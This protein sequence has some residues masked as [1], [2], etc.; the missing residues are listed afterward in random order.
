MNGYDHD[1]TIIV[2]DSIFTMVNTRSFEPGIDHYVISRQC[3]QVFY[4]EVPGRVGWSF[5]VRYD[6]RG[7]LVK[8]NVAEE[9][10]VVEKG[11]AD[12]SDE[13][14][15]EV[16]PNVLGVNA[17]LYDDVNEDMLKNDIDDY[18]DMVISTPFLNQMIH[19][20]SWMKN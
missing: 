20:L 18:V 10:D 17:I 1:R 7:R 2:H 6:P 12:V 16:E 14:L 5:V 11:I 3:E 19:M 4:S 8:Y 9:D 15:E 13:D